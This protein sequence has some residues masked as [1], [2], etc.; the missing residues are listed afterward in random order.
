M[1]KATLAALTAARLYIGS[2]GLPIRV[3]QKLYA[4]LQRK[5]VAVEKVHGASNGAVYDEVIAR[6]HSLGRIIPSPGKDY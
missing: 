1:S 2:E 6:A 5:I 3:Q 4:K